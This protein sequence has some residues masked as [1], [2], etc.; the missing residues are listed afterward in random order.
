MPVLVFYPQIL[1]C[2]RPPILIP[3]GILRLVVKAPE[4]CLSATMF[5][6]MMVIDTSSDTLVKPPIKCFF[7]KLSWSWYTFTTIEQ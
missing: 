6:I 1:A 5:P 4:T 7:Y 2:H 3:E